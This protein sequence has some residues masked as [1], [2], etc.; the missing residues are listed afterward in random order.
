MYDIAIVGGGLAGLFSSILLSKSGFKVALF[1]K[2]KYPFHKVCGEYISNEVIPFLEKHD[3]FPIELEP[4][5]IDKLVISSTTG[6]SFSA[7]LDLGGFGISRYSYDHWL[8]QKTKALGTDL[9]ENTQV[10][11]ISK[12][13]DWF[14]VSTKTK[15]SFPTKLVIAAHG[16]RTKLDQQLDRKF[17]REHSPYVGVKYHLKTDLPADTISLHN[18]KGGYCGVS[19]VEDDTFNLCYLIHRD[20]IKKHGSIE[21]T[22]QEVL[23]RN[24]H[25]RQIFMHSDFLFEK[26]IV[27]NEV[28]FWPKETVQDGI[29]MVGDAAGTITPLSGNGMS[30]AIRSA[31]MLTLHLCE[32]FHQSQF[33]KEA[34]V[35]AYQQAWNHEFKKQM[36]IG[37][38]IQRLYFGNPLASHMAVLTGKFAKSLTRS[39]IRQ[40]H[41]E[42]FS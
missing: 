26:P 28:A 23:S 36:W 10:Q 29:L 12:D 41:G 8:A 9:F 27:I 33:D 14:I 37:R 40:T 22:E 5:R 15:G 16:K 32:N 30:I 2:N 24:P 11:D 42:P 3:L 38:Q 1:E 4:S 13:G 18:F 20:Q 7:P 34:I 21:Q 35:R 6:A 31:K 25:L 39:L 19:Q 17:I